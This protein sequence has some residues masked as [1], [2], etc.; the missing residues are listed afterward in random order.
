MPLADDDVGW[1][2]Y[3]TFHAMRLHFTSSYD[4]IKYNGKMKLS[5]ESFM[6]HKMRYSF[7]TLERKY[8]QNFEEF[9]IAN[10]VDCPYN[11]PGKVWPPH[12]LQQSNHEVYIDWKKRQNSLRQRFTNDLVVI[13]EMLTA[14]FIKLPNMLKQ[15]PNELWNLF[16]NNRICIETMCTIRLFT[17][18]V[19]FDTSMDLWV[20]DPLWIHKYKA[21]LSNYAPFVKLDIAFAAKTMMGMQNI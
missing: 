15:Y 11:E 9:A 21:L 2:A 20:N 19:K 12:L 8:K 13:D 7:A 3:Q 1:K 14:R 4:Y 17:D 18:P 5:K 16:D 6:S 10:F